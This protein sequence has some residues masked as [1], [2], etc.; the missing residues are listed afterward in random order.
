MYYDGAT[1]QQELL[2][3]NPVPI[4]F[5]IDVVDPSEVVLGNS[6]GIIRDGFDHWLPLVEKLG[7]LAGAGKEDLA[8]REV[9]YPVRQGG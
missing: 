5:R 2:V 3:S 1:K 7:V 6:T 9:L 4:P 8:L